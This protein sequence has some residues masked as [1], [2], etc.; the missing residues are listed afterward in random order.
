MI[1]GLTKRQKE[2]LDFVTRKIE[3]RG[4]APTLL[5][6]ADELNL[7]SVSNIHRILIELEKKGYLNLRRSTLTVQLKS[8]GEFVSSIPLS[9]SEAKVYD[10]IYKSVGISGISPTYREIKKNLEKVSLGNINRILRSLEQK[11]YLEVSPFQSHGVSLSAINDTQL[12]S[13]IFQAVPCDAKDFL[14]PTRGKTWIESLPLSKIV[15][16]FKKADETSIFCVVLKDE[17]GIHNFSKGDFL[18]INKRKIEKIGD[19]VAVKY[20]EKVIVRYYLPSSG[21][22]IRLSTYQSMDKT[23]DDESSVKT[24]DIEVPK[25]AISFLGVAVAA[26]IRSIG[27][28]RS[29]SDRKIKDEYE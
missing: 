12:Y 26:I 20:K 22:K 7:K 5:E 11:G 24:E 4:E 3:V 27:T 25:K 14:L 8:L 16:N 6:I 9:T 13:V 19:I 2:V 21:S 17:R 1:D 18:F 10:F 29:L 28:Q 15:P 23:N